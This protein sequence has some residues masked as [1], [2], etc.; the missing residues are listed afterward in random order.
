MRKSFLF[1]LL[2][3][4][5]ANLLAVPAKRQKKTLIMADGSKVEA[6]FCGDENIHYYASDDGRMFSLDAKGFARE[7]DAGKIRRL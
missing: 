1:F 5:T 6:V 2:F 7:V 3:L 4:L